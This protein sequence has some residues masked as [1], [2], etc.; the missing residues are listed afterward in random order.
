[1]VQLT[2]AK[3]ADYGPWT[4]TL[5][6]DREYRLQVL[7]ASL[8]HRM[9]ELLSCKGALVFP[10]RAD[11]LFAVTN[12][13]TLQDHIDVQK[14][15][16]GEEVRLSMTIGSALSPFDANVRVHEARSRRPADATHR[17]YG[18]P[19]TASS[20]EVTI[21]HL[22]IENLTSR[23]RTA[24]PYE[25]SSAV[26]GLYARMSAF[27]ME[28]GHLAFFMGGDNF[29]VVA[30]RRAKKD[31]MEFLEAERKSGTAINC[32][33]GRGQT[34]RQAAAHATAALDAIRAM[35]DSGRP[36][37]EILEMP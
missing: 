22:D 28:R 1:M 8:Y 24:S 21:M 6:S 36:R 25:V 10:N 16:E 14:D 11:E 37:P 26:F 5:G 12:G 35:R 30:G 9:Q 29:M 31:T 23:G 17:I 4:L 13:L 7:Q 19:G 15:L 2:V 34:G 20:D 27:F 3:I 32:G 33:I 18:E